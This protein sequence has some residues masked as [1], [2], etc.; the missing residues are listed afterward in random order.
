MSQAGAGQAREDPAP[1]AGARP[2]PPVARTRAESELAAGDRGD[3][4]GPRVGAG[5]RSSRILLNAGFRATA[6]IG[7]KI[8]TAALCIV[9]ARKL[10]AS[11]LG[12]FSFGL[13][14]VGIVTVVGFFGQDI[15]LTRE[16][17]RDHS[18]LE[19]YYSDALAGALILLTGELRG[20]VQACRLLA[21]PVLASAVAGG[22][23]FL[24]RHHFAA[25]VPAGI[26]AYF[27]VLF[28][29][30]RSAFSD[31]FSVVSTALDQLRA[32]IARRAPAPRGAASPST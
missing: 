32:R 15:V 8:A 6:D 22:L 5:A 12:I 11:E 13:S 3:P 26:V 19:E 7:S 9:L 21:G 30:E 17:S 20:R 29:Y 10:S 31:D 25:T 2:G 23:M 27:A 28:S 24:L 16:V 18:R 1:N 14:F 4:A